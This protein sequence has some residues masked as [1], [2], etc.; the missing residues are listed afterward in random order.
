VGYKR[1]TNESIFKSE[2]ANQLAQ[3]Q[4][5]EEDK[6]ATEQTGQTVQTIQS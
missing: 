4:A 6:V 5:E 2:S 3:A 1:V